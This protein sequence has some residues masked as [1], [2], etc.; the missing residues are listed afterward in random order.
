MCARTMNNTVVLEHCIADFKKTNEIEAFSNTDAFTI[1]VL[2]QVGK[3]FDLTNAEIE[4]SVVDGGQDGGI[5]SVLTMVNGQFISTQEEIENIKFTPQ[6]DVTIILSQTKFETSFSESVIDKL[7]TSMPVLLNLES[8]ETML[9]RRFNPKLVDR[10]HMMRR[11]WLKST[12]SGGSLS[13]QFLYATKANGIEVNASFV[14][15]EKQLVQLTKEA[16]SQDQVTFKKLSAKQLMR[17]HQQPP[18]STEELR[19]RENP[20]PIQFSDTEYGY[21][22]VVPLHDYHKF[23]MANGHRIKEY[24]F[25]SNVRHFQGNVDVNRKIRDTLENDLARDFWWLNNG[26]SIIASECRPAPKVLFLEEVQIVNGLQ[27]SFLIAHHHNPSNTDDSRSLLVKVVVTNEKETIDKVI[28][29]S[30]SQTPVAAAVLRATD[31]I[32]RDI[33]NYFA[34]QGYWYDRRKN[35]YKNHGKPTRRIFT[36]QGTAQAI[37]SVLHRNPSAARANPTSLVKAD[38]SYARIFNHT[39]PYKAYL[40]CCLLN[41]SVKDFI[42]T[43][44]PPEAKNHARNFAYHTTR[45]LATSITAMAN[46]DYERIAALTEAEIANL[47]AAAQAYSCLKTILEEYHG[48]NPTENII[49]VAKSRRFSDSINT[50]L[51]ASD[52]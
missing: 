2:L 18:I 22:G 5:D 41:L 42:K 8:D 1:F 38:K 39:I 29:A 30:N 25:E 7:Y 14:S 31:E 32:Q 26:I 44:L 35:F 51:I 17:L 37:E 33:E 24:L 19:F 13:V 23:I 46:Y 43:H 47:H 27:T 20:I 52:P 34:T 48:Q 36:I 21:V 15:K 50:Y 12:S 4:E 40:N 49:N 10:I 28:S 9:L 45:I 3:D 16:M 11:L 6:T